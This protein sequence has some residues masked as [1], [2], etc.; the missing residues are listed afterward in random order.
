MAAEAALEASLAAPET[1]EEKPL[2]AL[3]VIEAMAPD[4]LATAEVR[5]GTAA[6]VPETPETAAPEKDC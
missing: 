4:A 1:M 3:P 2:A 5:M 6:G